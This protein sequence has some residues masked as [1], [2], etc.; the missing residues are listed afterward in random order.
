[1]SSSAGAPA[2]ARNGSGWYV[3]GVV[4]AAQ[5]PEQVDPGVS[6]DPAHEVELLTEGPLAAL[7]SRV[8]LEEFDEAHLPELLNDPAWLERKIRAHEQV[9]E[10]A[11]ASSSVVPFR[12]CT[13]YRTESELRR[14]LNERESHLASVLRHV[15]GKVELGV[16]V[17]IDRERFAG[18]LG[19]H[20]AEARELE[21]RV[22]RV[23]GGR[24]YLEQRRLDQLVSREL[25]RF[26]REVVDGSHA[27][28]CEVA[29]VGIL[30]PLQSP[31]VSGRSDE[32]LLNGAYLVRAGA[33]ELR[34]AVAELARQHAEL[35][36]TFEVTGPWPPYNFVP[37]EVGAS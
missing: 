3:Y 22:S 23:E 24:A 1:M 18:S 10:H 2:G 20:S 34:E 8:S 35:G 33:V 9:L 26:A 16:K 5:A 36:V 28:L 12:F 19:S 15:D 32:M 11:L 37:R 4:A 25:E 7:A 17:F 14:F 27:R 30:G 13:V 21:A 29:E 6:I 31:E